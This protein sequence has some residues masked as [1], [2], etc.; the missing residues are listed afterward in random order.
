MVDLMH[1]VVVVVKV[2]KEAE[3]TSP[4][5]RKRPLSQHFDGVGYP[6][7]T[8]SFLLFPFRLHLLGTMQ[9]KTSRSALAIDFARFHNMSCGIMFADIGGKVAA[10][11]KSLDWLASGPREV[12]FPP[13]LRR[14][15]FNSTTCGVPPLRQ[16]GATNTSFGASR[17]SSGQLAE[18]VLQ[19]GDGCPGVK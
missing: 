10:V 9:L 3:V 8:S 19:N 14:T 5:G 11:L 18:N 4:F 15:S 7:S 13:L 12:Y 17:C 1:L 6:P 2:V 16:R